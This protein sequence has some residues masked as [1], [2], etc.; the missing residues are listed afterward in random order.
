MVSVATWKA[1]RIIW[2]TGLWPCPWGIVLIMMIEL[3]RFTHCGHLHSLARILDYVKKES[4]AVRGIHRSLF[5]DCEYDISSCFKLSLPRPL[6]HSE[7][8]PW[9]VNQTRQN[10]PLLLQVAF[11]RVFYHSNG[12]KLCSVVLGLEPGPYLCSLYYQ[13]RSPRS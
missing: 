12:R 9:T 3:W 1:S 4:W 7:P 5:P 6:C 2:E 11:V 8:Y 10:K 13:T